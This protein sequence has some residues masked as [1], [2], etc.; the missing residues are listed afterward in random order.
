[1]QFTKMHGCGNDYIYVDCTK[2]DL[3]DK[4]EFARIY[5]DRHKGIGADGLICICNS[6]TADFR[7][8]MYNADGSEGDMCGNGIRCVGKYV[9]DKK[10]TDKTTITVETNSGIK[11]LRIISEADRESWLQVD[12]GRAVFEADRIPVASGLGHEVI[13]KRLSLFGREWNITCVNT[14]N[15]HCVIFQEELTDEL[16]NTFGPQ[17][18]KASI[19]PNRANIE[20]VKV[21]NDKE[22]E[23]RVWERGSGETMACGTGA[24]ASAAASFVNHKTGANVTVHLRGGDLKIEIDDLM[25]VRM[26]GPA[27]TVYEG[28]V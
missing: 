21:L 16:V 11:T 9:R 10:L 6:E 26:T 23:M 4:S 3:E 14:G 5:S 12:M 19:F 24:C 17:F 8:K 22:I 25:N 15:P 18:E 7:M 28:T 2:Y 13:D 20:F 1:M 27:E